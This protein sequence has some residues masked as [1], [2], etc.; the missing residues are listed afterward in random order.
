MERL[1]LGGGDDGLHVAH[2]G[3]ELGRPRATVA[4]A[5]EVASHA[6]AERLGLAHVQDGAVLAAKDVHAGLGGELS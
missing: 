3:D 6:G 2:P 4:S 1:H 5:L